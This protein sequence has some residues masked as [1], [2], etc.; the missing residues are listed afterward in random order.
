MTE[1]ACSPFMMWIYSNMGTLF[2]AGFLAIC[3]GFYKCVYPKDR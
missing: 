3:W 2:L 1:F